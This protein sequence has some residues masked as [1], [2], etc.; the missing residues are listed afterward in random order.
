MFEFI[1]FAGFCYFIYWLF[2]TG[3]KGLAIF[4]IVAFLLWGLANL[5]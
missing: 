2:S 4:L 1:L 3:K 5:A